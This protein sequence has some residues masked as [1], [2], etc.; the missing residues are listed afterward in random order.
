MA[1][2]VHSPVARRHQ[3][4]N[5]LTAADVGS[6]IR[7]VV[8]AAN[9]GGSTSATSVP[10][11][12]VLAAPASTGC[13]KTGGTIPVSGVTAPARLTVD[14]TQIANPPRLTYGS[15]AL[16][17]RVHVTACGGSVQGALVY[18]TAVPY[19]QFSIPA[20]QATGADGWATL[21]LSA[22]AGY[23][24]SN[25]QQLI[26]MFVRARKAGENILAGIS[27]RRLVSFRV[28]RG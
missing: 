24:V 27:T 7:V 15:R 23:P 22:L 11:G 8:T 18:T 10:T 21:Q 4:A 12:V 1:V 2:T 25:K 14:A 20:E 9:P 16:T 3:T 19:G 17:L 5:V 28:T 26:V 6:T 13:T